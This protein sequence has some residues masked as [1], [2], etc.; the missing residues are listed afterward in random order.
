MQLYPG[1]PAEQWRGFA[2][3]DAANSGEPATRHDSTGY[4]GVWRHQHRSDNDR[5]AYAEHIGMCRGYN[6][7]SGNARHD[8]TG[9][10]H[11]RR[12]NAGRI[13]AGLLMRERRDTRLNYYLIENSG[14]RKDL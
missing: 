8:D 6:D 9:Q 4:H 13:A 2:A 14:S 11:G 10:R 12:G 3:L 1:R 7:E 5:G